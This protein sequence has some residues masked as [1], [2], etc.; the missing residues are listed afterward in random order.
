MALATYQECLP[1][2][3]LRGVLG[4][5]VVLGSLQHPAVPEV[6]AVLSV[7]LV[8]AVPEVLLSPVSLLYQHH[9]APLAGPWDLG[10]LAVPEILVSLGHPVLPWDPADLVSHPGLAAQVP[11]EVPGCRGFQG[12]HHLPGVRTVPVDLQVQQGLYH[13]VV[14]EDLLLPFHLDT[15]HISRYCERENRY[16]IIF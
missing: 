15:K 12:S 16:S 5:L 10:V 9:H 1:D 13:H 2:P 7:L 4:P 14:L 11:H 8:R 6:L 3:G